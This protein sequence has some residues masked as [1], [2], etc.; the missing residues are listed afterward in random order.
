MSQNE[1]TPEDQSR[2]TDEELLNG[3]FEVE[4]TPLGST[5]LDRPEV[6][7][8]TIHTGHQCVVVLVTFKTWS[9]PSDFA[10]QYNMQLVSASVTDG[11]PWWK[12]VFDVGRGVWIQGRFIRQDHRGWGNSKND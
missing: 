2:P 8:V 9:I 7:D 11:R 10:S 6:R 1:H 12:R 3:N 4:D 5:I